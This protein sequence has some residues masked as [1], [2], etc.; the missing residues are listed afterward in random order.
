MGKKPKRALMVVT[1]VTLDP[2]YEVVLHRIRAELAGRGM[3]STR[4]AAVREL[5][6]RE[7]ERQEQA[8]QAS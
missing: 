1:S 3:P 5:V 2:A 4:S 8:G 7:A 6:R